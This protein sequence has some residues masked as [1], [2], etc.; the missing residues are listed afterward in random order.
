MSL[1][2]VNEELCIKC[3][4]CAQVCPSW[5]IS[6]D[7][8]GFPEILP[9]NEARCIECGH[10]VLYCPT[11]ANT[12]SF[13]NQN[14]L[15]KARELSLPAKQEAINFIKSR[16]S[17]RRF[18]KEIISKELFAEIFEVV[19]Q[20][21][22][23][24]N[25]QPVRW[26]ISDDPQKTEEVAN[27]VLAWMCTFL[28]NQSQSPL[29]FIAKNMKAKA[30]EGIDGILRGAPHIAIAVVKSDY[31][32]PEDGTIALTYLELATQAFG[33]GACWG[34]FLTAAIRNNINL[35]KFLSISEDEHV[36]GAQL[37]GFP[38]N[39]PTRQFA[40]RKEMNINWL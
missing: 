4:L 24:S 12:L 10:C 30:D 22:T 29:A 6:F 34:G 27:M 39:L 28:E 32:W 25:K 7:E 8:K 1:F 2:T 33:V 11:E 13:I 15:L 23:A 17:I 36:C 18:K 21:P 9:P 5:L 3:S 31:K 19:N 40:P 35:R 26:I 14:K 37:L 20:A 38:K 16:R